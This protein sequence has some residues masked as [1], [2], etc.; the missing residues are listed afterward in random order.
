MEGL[1]LNL[2]HSLPE[3]DRGFGFRALSSGFRVHSPAGLARN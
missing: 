1:G 2:R 3:R